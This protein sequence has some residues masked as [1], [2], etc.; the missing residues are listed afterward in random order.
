LRNAPDRSP[1][2]V[3]SFRR[4]INLLSVLTPS[5]PGTD[6]VYHQILITLL[7][8]KFGHLVS[9]DAPSEVEKADH[10]SLKSPLCSCVSITRFIVN[11]NYGIALLIASGNQKRFWRD[12]VKRAAQIEGRSRS[13]SGSFYA[14]H[15]NHRW[16]CTGTTD[17]DGVHG[18]TA[19]ACD[20]DELFDL[21]AAV[22]A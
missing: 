11:A 18:A 8:R 16:V 3:D 10:G 7:I 4:S 5:V 17:A 2:P 12:P 6:A 1:R 21:I 13:D 9:R 19:L 20:E 14:A 15:G 22:R